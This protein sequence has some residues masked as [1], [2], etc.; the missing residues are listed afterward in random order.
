MLQLVGLMHLVD[1]RIDAETIAEHA[2]RS[3]PAPDQL[4]YACRQLGVA[5]A[6]VAPLTHSGAG[7]AA[8]LSAGLEVVGVAQG[9]QAERLRGF[10]A[11]HVVPTL[12]ALLDPRLSSPDAPTTER[13]SGWK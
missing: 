5:P 8:A 1:V 11:Q 2:L 7:V 12:E 9:A 3:Q 4:L 10:G 13:R 6:A